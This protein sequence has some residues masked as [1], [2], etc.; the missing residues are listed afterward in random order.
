MAGFPL[1]SANSFTESPSDSN[2]AITS[3]WCHGARKL[4]F[5]KTVLMNSSSRWSSTGFCGVFRG[6]RGRVSRKSYDSGGSCAFFII[7]LGRSG[8][9]KIRVVTSF[10]TGKASDSGWK[11]RWEHPGWEDPGWRDAAWREV[12]VTSQKAPTKHSPHQTHIQHDKSGA[13]YRWICRSLVMRCMPSMMA[14]AMRI[15]SKGSL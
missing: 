14:W 4:D 9:G 13:G 5:G 6:F 2:I 3:G 11:F 1:R 8:L 15:R 10:A 12:P 7:C